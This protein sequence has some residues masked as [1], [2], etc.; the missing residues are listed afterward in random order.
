MTIATVHD[1]ESSGAYNAKKYFDKL[2]CSGKP[3]TY[4]AVFVVPA[5]AEPTF[6]AQKFTG[7][8][9]EDMSTYFDQYV[10]GL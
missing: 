7:K 5:D 2:L 10:I 6:V 9:A 8:V 1:L 4:P 3:P